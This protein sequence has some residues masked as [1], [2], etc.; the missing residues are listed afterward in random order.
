ML[1]NCGVKIENDLKHGEKDELGMCLS[2]F[3]QKLMCTDVFMQSKT[4][5]C[6]QHSIRSDLT[7]EP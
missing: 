6:S 5:M 2:D 4:G 7:F 1:E 3:H